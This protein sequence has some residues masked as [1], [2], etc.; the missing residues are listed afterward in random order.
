MHSKPHAV[1]GFSLLELLTVI[2]I[3]AVLA[4]L[5]ITGLPAARERARRTACLGNLRQLHLAASLYAADNRDFVPGAGDTN[6]LSVGRIVYLPLIST[7]VQAALKHYAGQDRAMDCPNLHATLVRSNEWRWPLNQ[8]TVQLGYFYLGGRPETP[9]TNSQAPVV[10]SW[11]SPQRL[12]DDPSS[13]LFADLNYVAACSSRIVLAHGGNGAWL[14]SGPAYFQ[15][16]QELQAAGFAEK[17]VSGLNIVRLDGSA[18][19]RPRRELR[20]R[21]AARENASY[22]NSTCIAL[23]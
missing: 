22:D 18:Q 6:S 20:W 15:Q 8:R 9:W 19:W 4:A 23:W 7:N 11:V 2:A 21:R 5:V 16:A 17:A 14:R 3:I 1:R 13:L 12:A 10:G